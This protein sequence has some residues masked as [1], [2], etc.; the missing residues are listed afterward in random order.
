MQHVFWLVDN[1][2]C[3]RPGPNHQPWSA[4]ELKGG[5]IGAVLSVNSAES[6]YPDDL[7]SAGLAHRC[8]PL[9]ANAPPRPGE[10]DLCLERLP[11]AYDYALSHVTES[12]PVLVHCRHGKDRTGLFMA[13]YLK[14]RFDLS[15][16]SAVDA[17]RTRRPIAF[18][19]EG[20]HEF[21]L[22]VL[23]AC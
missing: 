2:I 6:V 21:A 19:A 16:V 1:E 13:Y 15:P 4:E 11:V 12:R 8:V 10:L 20:W 3:G 7:E 9:A 18:T 5:G 17:V 23:R 14:R 22:E